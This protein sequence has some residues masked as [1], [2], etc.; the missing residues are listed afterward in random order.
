ML[1]LWEILVIENKAKI[2]LKEYFTMDFHIHVFDKDNKDDKGKDNAET[3]I[4][5]WS[6]KGYDQMILC[7]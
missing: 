7:K 1:N 4:I 5:K 6:T 2:Q 3:L